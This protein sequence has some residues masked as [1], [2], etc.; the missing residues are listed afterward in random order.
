MGIRFFPVTL[1]PMRSLTK[2]GMKLKEM[3]QVKGLE[4]IE[5]Y[6]G[7]AQDL[8]G[9]PRRTDVE[10]LRLGL[11]R[12][13]IVGDVERPDISS[14]ELDAITYAW[15]GRL[16]LSGQYM[17]MG[18]PEEALMFLPKSSSERRPMGWATNR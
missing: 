8:L 5:T 1:G 13:G 16:F 2:S 7:G 10:G 3:L 4:V 17:A 12:I 6:S 11:K 18:S 9:L 14:H 15:V